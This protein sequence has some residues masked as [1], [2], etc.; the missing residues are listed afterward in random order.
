[1]QFVQFLDLPTDAAVVALDRRVQRLIDHLEGEARLETLAHVGQALAEAL[2]VLHP[3][4]VV[5]VGVRQSLDDDAGV[6]R[7]VDHQEHA[8][9]QGI[10]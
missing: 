1:M 9:P 6:R 4:T 8:F 7:V 2:G 3:Q 5:G 10:G